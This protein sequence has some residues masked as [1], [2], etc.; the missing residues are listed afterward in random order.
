VT[1]SPVKTP[2]WGQR[3]FFT[4]K[5]REWTAISWQAPLR[6]SSLCKTYLFLQFN[7]FY[8]ETERMGGGRSSIYTIKHGQN[9][10]QTEEEA[11]E[12]LESLMHQSPGLAVGM[13]HSLPALLISSCLIL[14]FPS[15]ARAFTYLLY[16]AMGP[17]SCHTE[18]AGQTTLLRLFH[19][20]TPR[21]TY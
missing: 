20:A 12:L 6:L 8:R 9:I 11:C 2:A 16:N 18:P 15:T 1:A 5:R 3:L 7:T 13:P 21:G 4:S 17:G 10:K 19:A 14:S